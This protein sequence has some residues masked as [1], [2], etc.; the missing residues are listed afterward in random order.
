MPQSWSNLI[1]GF[2]PVEI[3]QNRDRFRGGN[4]GSR[5]PR[6]QRNFTTAVREASLS[7][8]ASIVPLVVDENGMISSH[9]ADAFG[10]MAIAYRNPVDM[11]SHWQ[12]TQIVYPNL[13]IV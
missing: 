10:L 1:P 11:K 3:D 5:R 6:G 13:G 9:A 2:E 8:S 7:P 4:L 12:R